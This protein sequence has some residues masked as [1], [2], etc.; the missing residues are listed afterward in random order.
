M[1]RS[2]TKIVKESAG[3]HVSGIAKASCPGRAARSSDG[4][5][6][7]SMRWGRSW[8]ELT[9]YSETTTVPRCWRS[10]TSRSTAG[11]SRR[12]SR[13]L[14]GMSG[15]IRFLEA[16]SVFLETSI[17]KLPKPFR[18]N[19]RLRCRTFDGGSAANTA[20]AAAVASHSESAG[21]VRSLPRR[22]PP[23]PPQCR[24]PRQPSAPVAPSTEIW[25]AAARA[26]TE[27]VPE[28]VHPS[29][30]PYEKLYFEVRSL[31]PE[32]ASGPATALRIW[33][34]F[35]RNHL[36]LTAVHFTVQ[37]DSEVELEDDAQ[38]PELEVLLERPVSATAPP[39]ILAS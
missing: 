36:P 27:R 8:P 20:R 2:R 39:G 26:P 12:A 19:G 10:R 35:D 17:R 16:A 31:W 29:T 34:C 13:V 1:K 37:S 9:T 24:R 18:Q 15:L 11:R 14:R 25:H 23:L 5:S 33:R 30:R 6:P 21:R 32:D 22:R 7:K 4:D 38:M 28:I 3:R